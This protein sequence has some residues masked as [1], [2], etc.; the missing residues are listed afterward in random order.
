[1]EPSLKR[2]RLA[3]KIP[4]STA[5]SHVAS[6][7]SSSSSQ[8]QQQQQQQQQPPLPATTT[9]PH[10]GLPEQVCFLPVRPTSPDH[11]LTAASFP[12][13]RQPA[14]ARAYAGP[15]AAAPLPERHDFEAFA[16]HLQDAAMHI[17]HQTHK[18]QY[19]A[20]SVLLLRWEEDESVEADV[21]SLEK[22]FRECYNYRTE[23]WHIPTVANPS[24]KLG[25]Q[26]ASFLEHAH[27]DHLLIIYYAGCG[28][29][30][31]DGQLYWAW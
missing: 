12:L 7:S 29:V 3:P 5:L 24:I 4:E 23:T 9:P 2:R 25:V 31:P 16:R 6:S 27:S 20:V 19:S 17:Y 22:V 28:Y 15:D 30:S 18:P 11:R 1:M 21:V 26:M 8:P 10:H 13:D 14:Q